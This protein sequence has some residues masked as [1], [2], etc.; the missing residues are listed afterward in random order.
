MM[1]ERTTMKQTILRRTILTTIIL[2]ALCGGALAGNNIWTTT[3]PL[4]SGTGDRVIH[5]FAVSP[6][7]TLFCGT[8]GGFVYSYTIVTPPAAGF[9]GTPTSGGAPLAV[10]FNDTSTGS[11]GMWN[12][13]FGDNSWSNTT[14]STA[15][16]VTHTYTVPGTYTVSLTVT[17]A[18]DVSDTLSRGDY[19]AVTLPVPTVSTID[20]ATGI[21]TGSVAA[22][23]TGTNFN[24]TPTFTTTVRLT[25]AGET[26]ITVSGLTPTSGTTIDVTLPITGTA[27]GTWYVTVVNP[28]GQEST[29]IVGFAVTEPGM[30]PAPSVGSI[31]PATGINT[32]SVTATITGTNFNTTPGFMSTVRLARAG[33]TDITVSGLTPASGTTI[34]VTLPITG[35]AAGTWNIVVISPDGQESTESVTFEI[36]A[37]TPTPVPTPV[38]TTSPASGGSSSSGTSGSGGSD[39]DYWGTSSSLPLMTVTVNI[40][41]DSK[42]WQAIVTGTKLT[43]LIVTG[44]VQPG[45]GNNLTAPPGTVYQYFSLIPAR[46]TSINK[47]VINFTVPQAWLDENHIDPKSI[48][49]YHQTANGWEALPTTV[50]YTKDGTVYFSA[51]STGF[52]LFA[53]A[54]TPSAATPVTTT[55]QQVSTAV[56][57][58]APAPAAKAPVTTQTTAPPATPAKPAA[59]SPLLNLVL[60]IAA[61]GVLAGGGFMVRRWWIRRQN[62]ELFREYD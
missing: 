29:Q 1:T 12:W 33:E 47:A 34:D 5:A 45:S 50:L 37:T 21:N 44:T 26:D 32:G 20:P 55:N 22:T 16:N 25:R 4:T 59:P 23:I 58:T 18:A 62:P 3:G 43:D 11:V 27:T 17:N 39:D 36:T 2:L 10:Q 8:G 41:G 60:I 35:A 6:D 51:Q 24:T 13:S 31:N 56:Q 7:G 46:Y 61:I 9:T 15:R 30:L 28:D 42:A 40:G 57:T 53:I 49:L 48:V 52:S 14:D 19:I 54:G 38:P